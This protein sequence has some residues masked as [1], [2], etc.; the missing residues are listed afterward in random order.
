MGTEGFTGKGRRAVASVDLRYF[1]LRRPFLVRKYS[2]SAVSKFSVSSFSP[3]CRMTRLP[4]SPCSVPLD[5]ALPVGAGA[6]YRSR[7]RADMVAPLAPHS[8]A[9]PATLCMPW[10]RPTCATHSSRM[11][12]GCIEYIGGSRRGCARCLSIYPPVRWRVRTYSHGQNNLHRPWCGVTL[13]PAR[14]TGIPRNSLRRCTWPLARRWSTKYSSKGATTY[15][16]THAGPARCC[17]D[18]NVWFCPQRDS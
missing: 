12:S 8:A 2:S 14:G 11:G 9:I 16:C 6:R 1:F 7:N 13:A 4:P 15:P 17:H 10:G 18:A 5:V 3:Y